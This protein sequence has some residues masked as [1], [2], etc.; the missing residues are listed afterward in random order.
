MAAINPDVEDM[1]VSRQDFFSALEEVLVLCPN[2]YVQWSLVEINPL[3]LQSL[4]FR[5]DI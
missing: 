4:R 5:E 2:C 1:K 3:S